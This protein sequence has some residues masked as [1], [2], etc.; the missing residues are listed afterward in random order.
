MSEKELKE[1][2]VELTVENEAYAFQKEIVRALTTA[3]RK[4]LIVRTENA[5]NAE[6]GFWVRYE[7]KWKRNWDWQHKNLFKARSTAGL[8]ILNTSFKAYIE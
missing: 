7:N 6:D 3:F 4:V 8:C 1:Q 2:I 5:W